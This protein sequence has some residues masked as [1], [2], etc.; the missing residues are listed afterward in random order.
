MNFN[1]KVPKDI[2]EFLKSHPNANRTQTAKQFGVSEAKIRIYKFIVSKSS[3]TFT[4]NSLELN[5]NQDDNIWKINVEEI[6]KPNETGSITVNGSCPSNKY[7]KDGVIKKAIKEAG[8]DYKSWIIDKIETS[9]WDTSMK[10]R[11]RIGKDSYEDKVQQV[12]NWKVGIRLKPLK[13][14]NYIQ[15]LEDIIKEL[16]STTPST[17]QKIE[18]PYKL[19][20]GDNLCGVIE[21]ADAHI[22]K[23]AWNEE[24]LGGNMNLPI[25]VQK[26]KEGTISCLNKMSRDGVSEINIII[27]HD[28]IHIDNK[29]GETPNGKNQLDFD[30]RFQKIIRETEKATIELCDNA[31]QVAPLNII[32]V[33]GNH[34]YV[35]SYMLCRLLA[36]RYRDDKN[37]KVDIGASQRKML[38]WGDNLIGFVHEAEGKKRYANVNILAQFDPWK[39]YWSNAKWLELHSGHLHKKEVETIGGVIYRRIPALSTIDSWHCD[40][41][42]TDAIPCCD[43]FVYH[44][45]DGL[46]AEYPTNIKY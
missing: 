27:G 41:A 31:S 38:L 8:I 14:K 4:L 7:N 24:T 28:L 17:K 45:K 44:K 22:G 9:K 23:F 40:N 33:P 37:I 1:V 5:T 30:T 42:F 21:P 43:S 36:Q 39:K 18:I 20:K 6:L 12:T 26:F 11:R 32:W 46:Y 35:S 19:N 16:N 34:D 25:A 13:A 10:M 15:A 3:G 2:A 29:K